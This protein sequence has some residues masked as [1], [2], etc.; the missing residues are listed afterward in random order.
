MGQ[1]A[2]GAA[3]GRLLARAVPQSQLVA[4]E[5]TSRGLFR[6][7]GI[8]LSDKQTAFEATVREAIGDDDHLVQ[9]PRRQLLET[10][11]SV[12]RYRAAQEQQI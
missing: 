9:A 8:G 3:R 5:N 4:L 10:R 12:L 7:E 6:R 1:I 2:V 11:N